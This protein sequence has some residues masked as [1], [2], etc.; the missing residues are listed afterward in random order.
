MEQPPVKR[1]NRELKYQGT[2]LKIYE[3]TVKPMGMRLTGI[4]SI[5]TARLQWFL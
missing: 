2:I 1:L 5:T 4:L 3:D